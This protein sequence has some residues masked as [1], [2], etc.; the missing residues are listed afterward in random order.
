M[1]DTDDGQGRAVTIWK[2]DRYCRVR[3]DGVDIV[4]GDGVVWVRGVAGDVAD[5]GEVA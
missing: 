2:L 5:D 4:D 3:E 1:I